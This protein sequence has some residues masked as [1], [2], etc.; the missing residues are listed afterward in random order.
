MNELKPVQ[1]ELVRGACERHTAKTA[2]VLR[3]PDDGETPRAYLDAIA[4][5]LVAHFQTAEACHLF[6]GTRGQAQIARYF[7]GLA[8]EFDSARRR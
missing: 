1:Q 2:T 8:M 4:P 5:A 7:H 3:P 6:P